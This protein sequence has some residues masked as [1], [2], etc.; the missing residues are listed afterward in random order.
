MVRM[1]ETAEPKYWYI[2]YKFIGNP[3]DLTEKEWYW[4]KGV[5][6]EGLERTY[7]ASLE[8]GLIEALKLIK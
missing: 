6:S 3:N 2:V 7:E 8:E 5:R 1:D 4:D